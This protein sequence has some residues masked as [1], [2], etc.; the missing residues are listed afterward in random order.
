ME[1]KTHNGSETSSIKSSSKQI[2]INKLGKY[3]YNQKQRSRYKF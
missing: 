1:R 2:R 3:P